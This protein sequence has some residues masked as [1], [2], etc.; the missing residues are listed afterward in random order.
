MAVFGCHCVYKLCSFADL[1]C[2]RMLLCDYHACLLVCGLYL[3]YSY[4]NSNSGSSTPWPIV[5]VC[6]SLYTN[7]DYR[8]KEEETK[9]PI[10][11]RNNAAM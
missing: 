10:I 2:A 3:Y 11:G 5:T 7:P 6:R 9:Q 8:Y 1:Q 4:L